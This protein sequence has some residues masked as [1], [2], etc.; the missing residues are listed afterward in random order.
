MSR[1]VWCGHPLGPNSK[2]EPIFFHDQL[3]PVCSISCRER[4]LRYLPKH[5]RAENLARWVFTPL[6]VL[7]VVTEGILIFTRAIPAN[8]I[9][10]FQAI[11][12]L[13]V[14]LVLL[15]VPAFAKP[16]HP[17]DWRN[18]MTMNRL[19]IVFGIISCSLG[20]LHIY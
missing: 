20:V 19:R 17:I 18:L 6:T 10:I 13:W 9:N 1:C 16:K 7:Y 5:Q 8:R 2:I 4:T 15:C 3:L 11:L 12:W 14:G